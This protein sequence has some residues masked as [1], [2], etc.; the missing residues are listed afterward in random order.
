MEENDKA[1]TNM[2]N[3]AFIHQCI[4][5]VNTTSRIKDVIINDKNSSENT[6]S[7]EQ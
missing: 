5:N 3:N 6:P 2:D 1:A 4:L 7:L